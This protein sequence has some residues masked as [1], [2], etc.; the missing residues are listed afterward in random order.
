M[1]EN[2]HDYKRHRRI[3]NE[4]EAADA[5]SNAAIV[6]ASILFSSGAFSQD[7][8]LEMAARVEQLHL[9]QPTS[10][11]A[12]VFIENFPSRNYLMDPESK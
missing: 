5:V 11:G 9:H 3:M 10:K 12:T 7:E 8:S 6:Y 2:T 1:T 4:A